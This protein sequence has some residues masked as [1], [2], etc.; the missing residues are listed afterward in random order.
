MGNSIR[1]II[2]KYYDT[3]QYKNLRDIPA[4]KQ[5]KNLSTERVQVAKPQTPFTRKV[6]RLLEAKGWNK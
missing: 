1:E 4:T 3:T 5:E 2:N 6:L